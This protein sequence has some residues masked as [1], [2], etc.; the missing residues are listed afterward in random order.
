[1]DRN[2]ATFDFWSTCAYMID[3]HVMKEAIDAVITKVNGWMSIKVVAG[4]TSP[5]VP[6]E[7]CPHNDNVF[8]HKPPCV[9]A[10]RGY[11]ADSFLYAMTKTYMLSVPIISNGAGTIV[12]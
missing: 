10:P 1:M 3:R 7:C 9:Y 8:V 4:I 2:A 12:S 6:T 5:C 11:Q